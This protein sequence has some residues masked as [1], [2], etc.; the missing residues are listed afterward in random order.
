MKVVKSMLKNC[1]LI[2]PNM[3]SNIS[4]TVPQMY[5]V[6][7]IVWRRRREALWQ[8]FSSSG[9]VL[10]KQEA[11]Q[12]ESLTLHLGSKQSIRYR[13]P[14]PSSLSFLFH[15]LFFVLFS[16]IIFAPCA[17]LYLFSHPL[18][19]AYIFPFLSSDTLNPIIFPIC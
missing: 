12:M 4:S 2:S 7:H 9:R 17:P 13:R 8:S 16:F 10:M 19:L 14:R 11:G 18:L 6:S 15:F 1:H 3:S 5:R